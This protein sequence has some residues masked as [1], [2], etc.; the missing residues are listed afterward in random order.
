M[1]LTPLIIVVFT[2]FLC[3]VM[4][5]NAEDNIKDNSRGFKT[6]STINGTIRN[7]SS[8]GVDLHEED[9]ERRVEPAPLSAL[10]LPS[11]RVFIITTLSIS[12]II[13]LVIRNESFDV[14]HFH[15][16]KKSMKRGIIKL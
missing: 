15:T 8:S 12:F 11:D 5:V 7:I 4:T 6:I 16:F 10:D 2:L 3:S 1:K 14:I 13:I 9:N